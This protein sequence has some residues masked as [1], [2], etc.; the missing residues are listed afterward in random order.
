MFETLR[1]LFSGGGR[2]AGGGTVRGERAVH[3]AAAALVFEVVRADG[4][5]KP[6]ELTVMRAALQ[7]TL[8][9]GADELDVVMTLAERESR[10]AVSLFE[11][12][13]VLDE[14][15]SAEEK[16]RIVE[17]LWLVAFAD[18]RK[19]A[20]EEHLIRQIASLLHVQHPDF[21]DAKIRARTQT[22]EA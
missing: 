8:G 13:R 10:A 15:F 3:M 20:H 16:K 17:L 1:Q 4:E 11:F 5:V 6:E 19:D 2:D 7:G 18:R 12:T 9:L 14:T 21:I 22:D